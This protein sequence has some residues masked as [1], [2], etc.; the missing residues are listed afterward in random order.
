MKVC[1][2]P[3][4]VENTRITRVWQGGKFYKYQIC[5]LCHNESHRLASNLRYSLDPEYRRKKLESNR[6]SNS[7]PE[8]E[9]RRKE[10]VNLPNNLEKKRERQR[11][12]NQSHSPCC[13]SSDPGPIYGLIYKVTNLINGKIYVGKTV[14]SLAY[15]RRSHEAGSLRS[16]GFAFSS[17]IIKYGKDSFNWQVID[18]AVSIGCLNEKECRWIAYFKS[19]GPDGYNL[20]D[21]GEGVLG[22]RHS[23]SSRERIGNSLRGRERQPLS[24]EH[25]RKISE[26]NKK[27]A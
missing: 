26:A 25:K 4:T 11:R 27:F 12:R 16:D 3:R 20:T 17:A 10:I 23:K 7:R 19:H 18:T 8:A 2:H 9:A 13:V 5:R 15:R 6:L 21:G 24:E 22:L 14:N 1:N